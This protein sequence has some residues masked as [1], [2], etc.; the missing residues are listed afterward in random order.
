[1]NFGLIAGNGQFPFLVVDGARRAGAALAVVAIT[2]ETDPRIDEVADK[3]EWVSIGQLG[4]MIDFFKKE[5]VGNVIMAGQV[6]HVQIFSGALPDARML[7]MLWN[8]PKRNTDALIGGVA[9]EMAKEGIELIDSTYFIRE[10]LAPEGVISKRKP[11]DIEVENVEYGLH[12]ASEI[13]RLDLGQTIVV[14]A[15]ACVAVEAMEGT[16]ATIK[17]AGELAKGKLTVVKTAKPDQDMRFDVPVVGIPTIDAMIA[18]GATCLS[19][20]ADKT[21]IFDRDEMIS[22]ANRNKIA[23]IGS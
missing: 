17:R 22:L 3:V 5:E 9:N 13:A 12:L 4:K 21:L 15:K 1:M 10:H 23:I 14:R 11:S 16:D 7:K 18:A 2:Q 6:K 20:T 19:V 8:L